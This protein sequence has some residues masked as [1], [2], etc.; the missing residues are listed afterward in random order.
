MSILVLV[1]PIESTIPLIIK[2]TF[3]RTRSLTTFLAATALCG[4]ASFATVAQAQ[5]PQYG[6]NVTHEQARKAVAGARKQ[7][8]PMAMPLL[9]P[10]AN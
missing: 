3:K 4:L 7:N 2:E 10:V 6:P 9:T 1:L 8:L 5:V